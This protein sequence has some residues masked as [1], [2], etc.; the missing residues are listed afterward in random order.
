MSDATTVM[1]LAP[2]ANVSVLLQLALALP[3]AVPPVAAT[4]FTITCWIPLFPRP[5][6]VAVPDS[7]ILAVVTVCPAVWLVTARVGP[8]VSAAGAHVPVAGPIEQ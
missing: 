4:P 8:V 6:S 2:A 1:V 3:V 7:V 5:E